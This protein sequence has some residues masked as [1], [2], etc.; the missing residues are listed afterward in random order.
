MKNVNWDKLYKGASMLILAIVLVLQAF[1]SPL[2][3]PGEEAVAR[4]GRSALLQFQPGGDKLVVAS[5]G[6]IEFASGATLDV[7]S[8][9]TIAFAAGAIS[10]ADVA[11]VTRQINLSLASFID[12]QTDAGAAIGFDTTADALADFVNSATDGTG[13]VI[14]FDDTGGTE[15]QS[16]E[17]CSQLSVPPDYVSGGA[18][19]IRALKDAHTGATEIINCAV[20]V[21]GAALETAGT[22]TTSAA[23]TTSYTC[24]PTIAALA[25]ADSLSFY[26]SITSSGTMNDVVDIASVAFSYTASQ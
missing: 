14:R 3:L 26:L 6:E 2:A 22:V 5:G 17:V 24:T 21:N 25:A 23:A 11:N 18:F 12:C 10:A 9:T 1:G 7:Q 19:V 20:S 13:F 8:G 16:M 15:D 4:G